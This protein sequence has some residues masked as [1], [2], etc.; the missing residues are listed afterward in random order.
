VRRPLRFLAWRLQLDESQVTE[1]AKILS[2]LKTE[3]A[4]GEV[5]DRRSLTAFADAVS[6]ESFD[7][8]KVKAAADERVKS[9]ERIQVQVVRA[10]GR[11]H[12]LLESEQREK[13]AYLIRTGALVM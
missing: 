8:A 4:Q 13:L 12:A 7:E 5:D 10:L 1:F 6:G 3:R 2:D 9:L 11:I